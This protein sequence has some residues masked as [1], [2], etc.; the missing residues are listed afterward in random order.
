MRKQIGKV[1][2]NMFGAPR[3][4]PKLCYMGTELKKNNN[5]KL[6]ISVVIVTCAI[7]SVPLKTN[8]SH[9]AINM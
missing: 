3:T 8:K 9:V 6:R 7:Y 2:Q 1:K 4:D 5:I